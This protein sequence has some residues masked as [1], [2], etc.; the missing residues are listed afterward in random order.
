MLSP[1]VVSRVGA[2]VSLVM[3]SLRVKAVAERKHPLVVTQLA[4][5]DG[6]APLSKIVRAQS[7]IDIRIYKAR[8]GVGCQRR[9]ECLIAG[10]NFQPDIVAEVSRERKRP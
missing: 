1:S 10:Q 7:K 3:S 9:T 6:E 4:A 2:A 8:T 5:I